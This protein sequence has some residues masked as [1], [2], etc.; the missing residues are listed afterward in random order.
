MPASD[1]PGPDDAIAAAVA[2]RDATALVRHYSEAADRLAAWGE[3]DASLFFLTHA[4]IWALEAGLPE[5]RAIHARL[6]EAGREA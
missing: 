3:G 1:A 6:K 5:A 4:Y 2:R